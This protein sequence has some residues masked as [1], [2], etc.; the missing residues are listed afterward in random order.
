MFCNECGAKN[1]KSAVYC[2][3]CGKKLNT[4]DTS[5]SF[6]FKTHLNNVLKDIKGMILKPIDTAKDFIKEENYGVS[7]IYL[8]INVLIIALLILMFVKFSNNMYLNIFGAGLDYSYNNFLNAFEIPYFRIFLIVIMSGVIVHA[9]IAEIAYLICSYIFKSKTTFNKLITWLGINSLFSTLSIII[10]AV[11]S[12]ISI[13]LGLL[14]GL[15]S[16]IVCTYNHFNSFEFATDVNKNKL[17]YILTLTIT[18]TLLIVIYVL[19]KLFF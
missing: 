5:T 17:G 10:V 8:S 4:E 7:L 18:I 15:I 11:L 2:N 13:K 12:L 3:Q 19:P 1:N 16:L 14:L 6:K 9:L